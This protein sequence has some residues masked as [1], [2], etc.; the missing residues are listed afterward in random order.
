MEKESESSLR[1]HRSP[2]EGRFRQEQTRTQALHRGLV[3]GARME[4]MDTACNRGYW[5][6]KYH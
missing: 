5:E 4:D 1:G 3:G 2:Y 6:S